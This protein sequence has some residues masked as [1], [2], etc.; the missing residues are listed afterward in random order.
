MGLSEYTMK[1]FQRV[2][3]NIA[4]GLEQLKLNLSTD[5]RRIENTLKA[6]MNQAIEDHKAIK[7]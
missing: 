6:M 3:T 4:L 5:D 2:N 7:E 1:G